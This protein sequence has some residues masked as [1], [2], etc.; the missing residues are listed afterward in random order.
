MTR[1]P[2]FEKDQVVAAS[3]SIERETAPPD[4][5]RVNFNKVDTRS[6]LSSLRINFC[7][8]SYP[9][10]TRTVELFLSSGAMFNTVL[11][12]EVYLRNGSG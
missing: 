6:S 1:A 12:S 3:N 9:V 5:T 7:G 10:A 11:V 4:L 8:G 2:H